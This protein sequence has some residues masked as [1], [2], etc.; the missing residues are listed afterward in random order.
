MADWSHLH[1]SL[2]GR[3]GNQ[4]R[5]LAGGSA[6]GKICDWCCLEAFAIFLRAYVRYPFGVRRATH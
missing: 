2:C 6:G 3:D 5:F 4:V 1:C